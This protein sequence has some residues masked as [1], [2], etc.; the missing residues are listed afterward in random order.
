MLLAELPPEM[1]ALLHAVDEL[2]DH[3]AAASKKRRRKLLRAV[4]AANDAIW[5]R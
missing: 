4:R 1:R 3:W 2:C 5:N